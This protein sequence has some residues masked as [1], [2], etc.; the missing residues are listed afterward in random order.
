MQLYFIFRKDTRLKNI[1]T[2]KSSS[3]C[4]CELIHMKILWLIYNLVVYN[5]QNPYNYWVK[6]F[7]LRSIYMPLFYPQADTII[8]LFKNI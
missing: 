4:L 3:Q 2:E 1:T 7:A 5:L 8:T 6:W